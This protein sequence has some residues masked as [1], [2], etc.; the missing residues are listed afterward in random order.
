M[1]FGM[2][3]AVFTLGTYYAQDTVEYGKGRPPPCH[4]DI[5][6]CTTLLTRNVSIPSV[7][8]SQREQYITRGV[9]KVSTCF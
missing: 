7:G 3:E 6:L 2:S 4:H 8:A 5:T 1:L 9:I